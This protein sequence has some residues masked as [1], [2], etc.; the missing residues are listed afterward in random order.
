ML[1]TVDYLFKR[2]KTGY[3]HYFDL[4]FFFVVLCY[5]NVKPFIISGMHFSQAVAIIQ[6]QVGVI[7]GVHVLYNDKVGSIKPVIKPN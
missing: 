5:L 3:I 4:I 1:F 6:S 7:K 2:I